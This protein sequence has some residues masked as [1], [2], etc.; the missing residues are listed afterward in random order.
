MDIGINLTDEKKEKTYLI[1]D[2]VLDDAFF[3]KMER[4]LEDAKRRIAAGE[5]LSWGKAKENW[6]KNL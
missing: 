4:D 6:F 1:G 3:Q 5:D 2:R